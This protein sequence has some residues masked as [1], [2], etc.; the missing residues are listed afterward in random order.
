[1]ELIKEELIEIRDKYGDERRS[2]LNILV[3]M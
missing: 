3:V 1:M 2:K